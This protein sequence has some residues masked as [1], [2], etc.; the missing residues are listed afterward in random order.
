MAA[1]EQKGEN[2][3]KKCTSI[4]LILILLLLC[5]PAGAEET[6]SDA[7]GDW[8]GNLDGV[9]LKMTLGAD[10]TY[11]VSIPGYEPETGS[12]EDQDG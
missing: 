8:Y 1:C 9:P 3:M 5:F 6:A 12:G 10:G 2:N 4:I 11:A 7:T